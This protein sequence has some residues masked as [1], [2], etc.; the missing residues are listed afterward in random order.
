MSKNNSSRI[1][2]ILT[3]TENNNKYF[4]NHP[5]LLLIMVI[6]IFLVS[7]KKRKVAQYDSIRSKMMLESIELLS[8]NQPILAMEKLSK[9]HDLDPS[10]RFPQIAHEYEKKRDLRQKLQ[11]AIDNGN[12]TTAKKLVD[13]D[14]ADDGWGAILADYQELPEA[15]HRV[16]NFAKNQP[17]TSSQALKDALSSLGNAPVVLKNNIEFTQWYKKLQK[18]DATFAD[19]EKEIGLRKLVYRFAKEVVI[20]PENMRYSYTLIKEKHQ[21]HPLVIL[22]NAVQDRDWDSMKEILKKAS[23][24]QIIAESATAVGPLVWSKLP[25][26]QR[27][28]YQQYLRS[29]QQNSAG[30]LLISYYAAE[31]GNISGLK[32]YLNRLLAIAKPSTI[33]RQFLLET[34]L[35]PEQYF[36]ASCWQTP[37]PTVMDLIKRISLV[38]SQRK[39][40]HSEK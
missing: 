40:K 16:A 5:S 19:R 33:H 25:H 28:T 23:T 6:S 13:N 34:A 1:G 30:L 32:I 18:I 31:N 11:N 29:P 37:F 4:R 21:I 20:N 7:C 27:I 17:Y 14:V 15:L 10:L 39:R 9:L 36:A 26:A 22:L 8:K 24:D 3:K 38:E 12:F 2:L 35:L